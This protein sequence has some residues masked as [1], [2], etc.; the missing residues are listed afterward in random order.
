MH[1]DTLKILRKGDPVRFYDP[2]T[3]TFIQFQLNKNEKRVFWER[4]ASLDKK[5]WVKQASYYRLINI[6]R[7]IKKLKNERKI[8]KQSNKQTIKIY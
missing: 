7:F 3:N 6:D 2:F 5:T 4:Y 1:P 8:A